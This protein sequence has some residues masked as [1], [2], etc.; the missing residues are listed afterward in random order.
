MAPKKAPYSVVIDTR[1]Q[2]GWTFPDN[3]ETVSCGLHA[4]DYSLLG[5]ETLIGIERK[6]IDDLVSTVIHSRKRFTKELIRLQSYRFKIVAVEAELEDILEHRYSSD[7]HPNSIIGSILSLEMNYGI[8]FHWWGNRQIAQW[9]AHKW[10]EWAWKK[11]ASDGEVEK[12]TV[13]P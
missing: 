7:A 10:L 8:S 9:M 11:C 1:E 12:E 13:I 2:L 3:V 6:S 5:F 4:A